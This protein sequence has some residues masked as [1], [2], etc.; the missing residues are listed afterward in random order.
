MMDE[1]EKEQERGL[2]TETLRHHDD[3]INTTISR[4]HGKC[5]PLHVYTLQPER[6]KKSQLK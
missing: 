2:M 3:G 1:R 6:L 4:E 5:L